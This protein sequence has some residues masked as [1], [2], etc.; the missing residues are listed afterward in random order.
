[1]NFLDNIRVKPESWDQAESLLLLGL[2]F[3]LA[4]CLLGLLMAYGA[5]RPSAFLKE[6]TGE[7]PFV[8]W[9]IFWPTHLYSNL[10]CRLWRHFTREAAFCEVMPGLYLGRR[11]GHD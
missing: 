1:M 8:S 9:M 3:N 4:M 6:P 5:R 2:M 11:L 7:L 10:V